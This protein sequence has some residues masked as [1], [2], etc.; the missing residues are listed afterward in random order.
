MD[1]RLLCENLGLYY[2]GIQSIDE[3]NIGIWI[4]KNIDRDN[5]CLSVNYKEAFGD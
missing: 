5:F 1:A 4:K 3:T 2:L